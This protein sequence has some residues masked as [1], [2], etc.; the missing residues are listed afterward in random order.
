MENTD[1]L[2]TT[3]LSI[4]AGLTRAVARIVPPKE[5]EDI[6]QE[7]YVKVCQVK[8]KEKI[9][10]PR[11]FLY[12]TARNLAFDYLKK[13]ETQRA[14]S[15]G[16]D[17]FL[18]DADTDDFKDDIYEQVAKNEEFAQFC[19]AV[20]QLPVQCRKVFVL[21]KVYGY[22]QQEIAQELELSQS[23]V[24]KH[25]ATGIKRCTYYMMSQGGQGDTPDFMKSRIDKSK[26][27]PRSIFS[28]SVSPV[29]GDKS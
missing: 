16:D 8:H 26:N 6:V 11:S 22:S 5:I 1:K 25:V 24:E 21:K 18:F 14:D 23:T 17:A 29:S 27:K 12:R 15:V 9:E 13:A 10:H 3:Y 28:A 7:T 19:D 4:Y 20:R 2:S